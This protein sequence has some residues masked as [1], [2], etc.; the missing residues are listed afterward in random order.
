MSLK[1]EQLAAELM[2]KRELASA[3]M[4]IKR[5]V[6]FYSADTKAATSKVHMGGEPG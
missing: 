3:E 2:L 5:E 1:R 6:G 4:Q